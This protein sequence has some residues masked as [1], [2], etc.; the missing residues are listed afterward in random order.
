MDR[1]D[2]NLVVKEYVLAVAAESAAGKDTFL[3]NYCI[4]NFQNL[5]LPYCKYAK[6]SIFL[7]KDFLVS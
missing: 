7:G 1:E 6:N 5:E 3:H 2:L 4:G